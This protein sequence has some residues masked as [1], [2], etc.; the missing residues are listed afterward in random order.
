[1]V[2]ALLREE[3]GRVEAGVAEVVSHRAGLA[4]GTLS[5]AIADRLGFLSRES[6]EAM[7]AAA[8]LGAEFSVA[9]LGLVVG[10]P[11][12]ALVEVVEEA[13]AAGVVESSGQVLR[14]RHALI[15]ERLYEAMPTAVRGA[16]HRQAAPIS[17]L[18]RPCAT[19]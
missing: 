15:R 11:P 3:P 8:L 17:G 2:D 9:G 14:F 5:A 7:R 19:R 16:L 4:S 18:D 1:M 6:W 13:I 10:R 12:S